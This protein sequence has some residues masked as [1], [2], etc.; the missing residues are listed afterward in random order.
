[1][2][3]PNNEPLSAV[4]RRRQLQR[5]RQPRHQ[6]A[7]VRRQKRQRKEDRAREAKDYVEGK[8]LSGDSIPPSVE[9]IN[10]FWDGQDRN[11]FTNLVVD[12]LKECKSGGTIDGVQ[13]TI[14]RMM[15]ATIEHERASGQQPLSLEK[16]GQLTEDELGTRFRA[17]LGLPD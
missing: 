11:R 4:D 12:H 15:K 17:V 14:D 7:K 2:A 13:R 1:M 5:Q 3:T 10:S 16:L 6:A 8:L 9:E